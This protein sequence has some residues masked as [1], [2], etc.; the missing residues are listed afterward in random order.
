MRQRTRPRLD[1]IASL[2]ILGAGIAHE[3]RNPLAAIRFNLDFLRDAGA[4]RSELEVIV[5]NVERIDDLVKKLLRF[6]RPQSPAVRAQSL[7]PP[8]RAVATL[9]AKQPGDRFAS[10]EEL[11]AVLED[12]E[13]SAW[14]TDRAPALQQ[15]QARLPK[16]RVSRETKLHGRDEDLDLLRECLT[17]ASAGQGNTV[18]LE[19]EA[20]IGKTRLVDAFLRDVGADDL[21]VLYGTYPPSGGMGGL[22]DAILGKFG[23]ARLADALTPYLTVTPSLVPAF[24]S[25][26]QHESP[27]TGAEP[28]SG[29]ALQAVVV[30][31]MQALAAEKPTVSIVDDLQ[32]APQESRD[33]VLAMA[34]AV[35]DR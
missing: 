20:G 10:S 26:I 28:L 11:H 9:L 18:F 1:R 13:H 12:A 2:G 14:W 6:A 33:I 35:E 5:K 29:D 34:R 19:G 16:I 21:H 17:L 32:F 8:V 23:E 24:A 15:E 7:L 25:L 22:T 31:L 4:D 30:H 3:I 27:P